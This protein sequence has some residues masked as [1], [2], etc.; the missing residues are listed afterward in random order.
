MMPEM[1][2]VFTWLLFLLLP[3]R[4]SFAGTFSLE[5]KPFLTIS[6]PDSRLDRPEGIA[7]TPDG[8]YVAVACFW[9]DSINFYEIGESESPIFVLK[10]TKTHLYH[11]H[12][13]A[14][15]PDGNYLF[16]ANRR[17][18]MLTIYQRHADGI[19][20]EPSPVKRVRESSFNGVGAVTFSPT[21]NLLALAD[22]YCN[23]ILIYEF[24]ETHL[25]EAPRSILT[26]PQIS[27]A[28]GLGFSPDGRLLA[29]T[30]HDNHKAL[31]FER[32][33]EGEALFDPTPIKILEDEEIPLKHPHSIAFHPKSE[34]FIITCAGGNRHINCYE[35][36]QSCPHQWLEVLDSDIVARIERIN[37]V[38]GGAKGVA[39]SPDGT[40]VAVCSPGFIAVDSIQFFRVIEK[41]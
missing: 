21:E 19:S 22:T 10:G 20:F 39:F 7:F 38:E 18:G 8:R 37:P 6:G 26:A 35:R 14:F 28:D 3:L 25:V 11:P 33:P 36:G 5:E 1:N 17:S 27:V 29:V 41:D 32:T 34:D 4:L 31:F 23:R 9:G 13:L 2:Q 16:V 40:I 30:S 15:S 12:D 24:D